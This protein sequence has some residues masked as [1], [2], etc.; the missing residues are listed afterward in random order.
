MARPSEKPLVLSKLR[1][2]GVKESDIDKEL[3]ESVQ[4]GWGLREEKFANGIT[5]VDYVKPSSNEKFPVAF[6]CEDP[7]EAR[8]LM[9]L[10]LKENKRA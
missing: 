2:L 10:W 1:R 7:Q 3:P 6:A 9:V 8:A 4:G 5:V